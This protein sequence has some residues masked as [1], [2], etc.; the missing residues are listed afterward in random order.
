ME[1]Q[2]AS[3]EMLISNLTIENDNLEDEKRLLEFKI[4]QLKV[5]FYLTLVQK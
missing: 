5:T 4:E 2:V 1:D 3:I